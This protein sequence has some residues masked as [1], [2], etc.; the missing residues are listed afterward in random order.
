MTK[1]MSESMMPG[2]ENFTIEI[3]GVHDSKV[4]PALPST[5]VAISM[6]CM[7]CVEIQLNDSRYLNVQYLFPVPVG[8]MTLVDLF[9]TDGSENRK[10]SVRNNGIHRREI[11]SLYLF[12]FSLPEIV[13][14][15]GYFV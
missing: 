5:P 7:R 15:G 6:N 10:S 12:S 1:Q 8:P 2:N 11:H 14:D 9:L 3:W 4:C 13:E